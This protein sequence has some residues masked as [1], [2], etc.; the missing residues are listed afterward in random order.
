MCKITQ[1]RWF[2]LVDIQH[3]VLQEYCVAFYFHNAHVKQSPDR[4]KYSEQENIILT[5]QTHCFLIYYL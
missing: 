4:N 5:V 2:A 1:H 3:K